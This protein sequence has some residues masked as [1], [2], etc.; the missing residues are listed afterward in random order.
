MPTVLKIGENIQIGRVAYYELSEG[1]YFGYQH[2]QKLAVLLAIDS[3]NAAMGKEIGIHIAAMN[4]ELT[5]DD[6]PADLLSKSVR[7]I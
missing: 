1:F 2:G 5:A 7:F 3:D 6:L 4:P